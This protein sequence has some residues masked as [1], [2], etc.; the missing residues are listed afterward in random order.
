MEVKGGALAGLDSQQPE[1]T[2]SKMGQENIACETCRAVYT[3]TLQY[4]T[5]PGEQHCQVCGNILIRWSGKRFYSD[6]RLVY[7]PDNWPR[8]RW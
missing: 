7:Q 5:A 1:P 8:G 3:A 2:F 6:F 4:V